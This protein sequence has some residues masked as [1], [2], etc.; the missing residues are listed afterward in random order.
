MIAASAKTALIKSKAVTRM[1]DASENVGSSFPARSRR[2]RSVDRRCYL[3]WESS[4]AVAETAYSV[5]SV[6]VNANHR[7]QA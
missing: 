4:K 6:S 1:T 2:E 5:Q 7:G 3:F